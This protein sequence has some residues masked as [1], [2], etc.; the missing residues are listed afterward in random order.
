MLNR[1]ILI[2]IS[3]LTALCV[4]TSAIA[5][6]LDFIGTWV[7]KD[8]NS[9]GVTRFVIK[10]ASPGK[11]SI[12]GFGA[13]KPEDCYMGS[14]EL[15]TYG[16]GI[17]DRNHKF[18]TVSGPSPRYPKYMNFIFTLELTS[19]DEINGQGFTQFIN[20][21]EYQNYAGKDTFKREK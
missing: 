16:T 6:P 5:V 13:C 11:L 17:N 18:A 4:M 3:G 12:Q 21:S 7:N 14:G 1:S 20:K 15:V 10:E 9:P 2:G 19:Q 8:P